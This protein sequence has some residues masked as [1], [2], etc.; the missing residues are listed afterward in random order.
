M[1]H[2]AEIFL[3]PLKCSRALFFRIC[4]YSFIKEKLGVSLVSLSSVLGH[5]SRVSVNSI[6]AEV[7]YLIR[8]VALV[9]NMET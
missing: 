9:F 8:N 1:V 2:T 4:R 6:V 7:L 5:V 3:E